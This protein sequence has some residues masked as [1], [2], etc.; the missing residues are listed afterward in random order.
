MRA[1]RARRRRGRLGD[2]RRER[3]GAGEAPGSPGLLDGGDYP[4]PARLLAVI[5]DGPDQVLPVGALEELGGAAAGAGVH[6]HVVRR[7]VAEGETPVRFVQL[8][9]GDADV[10]QDAIEVTGDAVEV[11]EVLGMEPQ[12]RGV[13][14]QQRGRP[15]GGRGVAIEGV[16]G[17]AG[18]AIQDR[19]GVPATAEGAIQ[20]STPVPR[21]KEREALLK[22]DGNVAGHAGCE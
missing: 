10:H 8:K 5:A 22:Q 6:A 20:V 13:S 2:Q 12:A 18:G 3:G 7:V 16:D 1:A 14:G 4:V 15:V 11:T 9:R 21:V 17:T 19:R